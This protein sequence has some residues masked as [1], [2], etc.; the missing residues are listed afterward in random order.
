MILVGLFQMG[1]FCDWWQ[2]KLPSV[3]VCSLFFVYSSWLERWKQSFPVIMCRISLTWHWQSCVSVRTSCLS[4]QEETL[5]RYL[6]MFYEASEATFSSARQ[7]APRCLQCRCCSA[8]APS[9][10]LQTRCNFIC[11][12]DCN[13][14][15]LLLQVE[16]WPLICKQIPSYYLS[17][18][19]WFRQAVSAGIGNK[20]RGVKG[21]SDLWAAL[22]CTLALWAFF[23]Y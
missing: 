2:V 3:C 18:C 22:T 14:T 17:C 21:L 20:L 15:V 1:T 16:Y 8:A 4:L 12:W 5:C 6:G 19:V 11:C 13:N 9:V 23:S 10:S 7:R